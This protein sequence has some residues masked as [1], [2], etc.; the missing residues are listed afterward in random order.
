MVLVLTYDA[1]RRSSHR[2]FKDHTALCERRG[3]VGRGCLWREMYV[4]CVLEVALAKNRTAFPLSQVPEREPKTKAK[5]AP[6]TQ[7]KRAK[8]EESV[9]TL[10][11]DDDDNDGFRPSRS[12]SK[13]LGSQASQMSM[14]IPLAKPK[15]NKA[16]PA[17]RARALF[18][19]DSEEEEVEEVKAEDDDDDG[20]TMQGTAPPAHTKGRKAPAKRGKAKVVV[21]DDDSDE[22]AVFKPRATRSRR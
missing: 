16:K 4:R 14:D 2:T 21:D 3:Y 18:I 7:G 20:L 19:P 5:V 8:R 1:E 22:E 17:K 12:Q 11:D 15:G 9:I 10:S 6:R 13:A